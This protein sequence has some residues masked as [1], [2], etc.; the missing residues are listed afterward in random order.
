M[1][2]CKLLIWPDEKL[3]KI[4][5]KIN[6]INNDVKSLVKDLIDTMKHEKNSAGIAAPQIGVNS[7]VFVININPDHNQGNG[8]NGYEVFINP[9]IIKKCGTF[10]WEEG[11]LSIPGESGVVTRFETISISYINLHG[12]TIEQE[13][14]TYFSGCFQH[15]L[16]HLNGKLWINYQ[17]KLKQNLIKEKMLKLKKKNSIVNM[18]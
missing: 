12:K 4:S 15:E 1:T 6:L 13:V 17:S 8:T 16:D 9:K 3:L 7:C 18:G 10:N 5:N 2:I 14:D 11:C